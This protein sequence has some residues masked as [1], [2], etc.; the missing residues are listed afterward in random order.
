MSCLLA[1]QLKT[2]DMKRTVSL[3]APKDKSTSSIQVV[4]AAITWTRKRVGILLRLWHKSTWLALLI[5][6][7]REIVNNPISNNGNII[8]F[9]V[10]TLKYESWWTWHNM[11]QWNVTKARAT[12]WCTN[13][14]SAYPHCQRLLGSSFQRISQHWLSYPSLYTARGLHSSTGISAESYNKSFAFCVSAFCP[15]Y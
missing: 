2:A 12:I 11:C 9:I 8:F 7:M 3:H 15:F 5:C 6:G 10:N 14:F 13:I 1:D 4:N